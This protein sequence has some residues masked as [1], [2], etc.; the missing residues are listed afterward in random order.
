MGVKGTNGIKKGNNE[1][2]IIKIKGS[3]G[4]EFLW[5]FPR[6]QFYERVT[7]HEILFVY[8]KTGW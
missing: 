8:F 4:V 5:N 7:R 2:K 6:T 3:F 1:L